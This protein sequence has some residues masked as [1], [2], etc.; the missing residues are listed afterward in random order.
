MC[1]GDGLSSTVTVPQK[2]LRDLYEFYYNPATD[3]RDPEGTKLWR[4]LAELAGL[5]EPFSEDGGEEE[6][7]F[8]SGMGFISPPKE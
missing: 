5:N 7:W 2:L 4:E 8:P 6:T 1:G 3:Y